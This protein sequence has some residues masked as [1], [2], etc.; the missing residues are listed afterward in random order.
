M[1]EPVQ[2]GPRLG[3]RHALLRPAPAVAPHGA[4]GQLDHVRRHLVER[5]PGGPLGCAGGLGLGVV[6]MEGGILPPQP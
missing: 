3:D 4:P 1:L 5:A 6:T 2:H